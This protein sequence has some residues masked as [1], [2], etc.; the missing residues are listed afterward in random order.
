MSRPSAPR[1]EQTRSN[2]EALP[3]VLAVSDPLGQGTVSKDGST[4][5]ATVNFDTNPQSLGDAYVSQV[6]KAVDRRERPALKVSYG[7]QLGQAAA[8]KANDVASE[9][10]GIAVA[11]LVLLAGFGS[12]IGG[13][14]PLLSAIIGVFTGLGLLGMVAAAISFGTSS[15]TLATM[16]GLGVGI[17]YALF[18]TTRHRQRLIEGDDVIDGGPDDH[19]RQRPVDRDRR[20]DGRDRHVRAVRVRDRLHRQAGAGRR[21][22]RHRRGAVGA[23]ARARAARAGRQPDRPAPRPHAGGRAPTIPTGR[24]TATP[25]GSSATRGAT[26]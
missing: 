6:D 3:H 11:L 4:A 17:D 25:S 9:L 16:M 5:Y 24:C 2:L 19:G 20:H 21:D 13:V 18:L 8:P 14:L 15:P 10:I 23:H 26:R 22:H 1:I 12:V 7:G